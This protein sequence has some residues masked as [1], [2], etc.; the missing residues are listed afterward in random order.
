MWCTPTQRDAASE[1]E[2]LG[3][4]HAD[5]Q[6]ADEPGRVRHRDGVDVVER[7]PRVRQRARH[8]RHDRREVRRDAS[9][10]TTPPNTRCTSCERMTS[11]STPTSSPGPRAPPPTSRRTTSRCRGCASRGEAHGRAATVVSR[12]LRRHRR[13]PAAPLHLHLCRLHLHPVPVVSRS[14]TWGT[15]SFIAIESEWGR[16]PRIRAHDAA[17]PGDAH[18]LRART[19]RRRSRVTVLSAR[20][21]TRP[22]LTMGTRREARVS[23]RSVSSAAARPARALVGELRR[24]VHVRGGEV[25]HERIRCVAATLRRTTG[26]GHELDEVRA[27]P[28]PARAPGACRRG[29]RARCRA[30]ARRAR[31]RALPS[32]SA[33]TTSQSTTAKS[34]A[35]A[36][37]PSRS[38]AISR[39]R[40]CHV[41]RGA[42][43]AGMLRRSLGGR[44]RA[45]QRRPSRAHRV[46][47]QFAGV[48]AVPAETPSSSRT[49]ARLA[50]ESQ[51]SGPITFRRIMPSRPMT[52][53]S[54]TPV[55]W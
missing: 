19:R 37:K 44:R 49:S 53:V 2:R 10:G 24:D 22:S 7:V 8:D 39:R 47:A 45:V 55:V 38:V 36:L 46:P 33:P 41:G 29:A 12:A 32:A 54:G 35:L 16:M 51:S 23:N 28:P 42:G 1:R 14:A 30:P 43:G 50:G 21:T 18:G 27:R 15:V 4:A 17:R 3:E 48:G 26:G 52:N 9:S 6:R 13:H 40:R 25:E 31:A 34:S 20:T 5:E 11:E